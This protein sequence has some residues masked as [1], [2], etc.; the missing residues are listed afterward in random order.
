MVTPRTTPDEWGAENR[1]YPPT[2]GMPGPRNPALTPYGIPFARA[3]AEARYRRVVLATSAQSGKTEN[4]LDIVGERLDTRPTPILYVGPS[5]EFLTDQFEPRLMALFDEAPALRRKLARGKRNK[6]TL[7]R[8]AGVTLRLAHAG[9]ST[10][11]KSDPA[12]LALVDEYDEMLANI[13]GQGDPLGLVDARGDTFA[14]FVAAITST[15]G[16][17]LVE[18]QHDDKSGLDFWGVADPDDVQSPIWRLWQEGTRH[19]WAWKCPY[20]ADWFVP[21][22][23]CLAVDVLDDRGGTRSVALFEAR[24]VPPA[25]AR[26]TA[27]VICPR[28]GCVITDDA[29][30]SMN[31]GGQFV[32]PG[33]WVD[34]DDV[35]CGE[36]PESS[37]ASFWVSG[38]ASPFVT[39]GQRAETYQTALHSRESDKVQTAINA[40][41]GEVYA[42][43]GGEVFE[44][45]QVAAHRAQYKRG[46]A[47][48]GVRFLTLGV[49]VQK[50]RLVYI[51]RG[52][53]GRARSW[54]IEE[55]EL[56]GETAHPE[57]WEDLADLLT[58]TWGGLAIR[59]G[60]ID[61]G[62]RPGKK[63]VLPINRVYE[64][65]RRHTRV[66]PSKGFA[67]RSRPITASRIEVKSDGGQQKFGLSLYLLD[68]D[69]WKSWVYERLG[70][71]D[72]A[73]GA[74][75]IHEDATEDYCK[76]IVSEV[77]VIGPS[78]RAKW[79][80]RSRHNHFLDAEA[81][82][83]ACAHLLNVQRLR[84][85]G[86]DGDA[87]SRAS[88][89]ARRLNGE[90]PSKQATEGDPEAS[91]PPP[92]SRGG[93]FAR[94][95]ARLNR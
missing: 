11:L 55:G 87:R 50:D 23:S 93:R 44:W 52:W 6:K 3:V 81:M 47:P 30:H 63:F 9:S 62:Y 20:C 4:I 67:S 73:P 32:A 85:D 90:P 70:Y 26:R 95:A 31:A 92:P 39:F 41:F 49:D 74:W 5:K 25:Q 76:Q 22:F 7:K 79:V 59:L 69:H 88:D 43:G 83:A 91:T 60:F 56:W 13:K 78:G 21:R 54:L 68:T 77:R 34:A 86:G 36:P 24:D 33:Q 19:H 40:G 10:A 82:A 2:T 38:L 48:D 64:F 53:G 14:D 28:N 8:V 12:G 57:V 42:P 16:R 66:Y 17:G 61:S 75:F 35:V 71:P 27:H 29:K 15:P 80:P 1:V 84:E 94:M 58:Q 89:V 18:V 65:C 45:E 46:Q 72:D 51:V 37:T